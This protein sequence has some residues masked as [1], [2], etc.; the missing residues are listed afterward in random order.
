MNLEVERTALHAAL[1]GGT[2]AGLVA[3]RSGVSAPVSALRAL[4]GAALLWAVGL[5]LGSAL[6]PRAIA[7]DEEPEMSAG[8]NENVGVDTEV[9]PEL[10]PEKATAGLGR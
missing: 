7:G 4:G 10:R 2:L 3:L 1:V 6:R 8:D 9:G 5:A